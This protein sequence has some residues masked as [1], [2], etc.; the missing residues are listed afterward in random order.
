MLIK[1]IFAQQGDNLAGEDLVT[2]T[3]KSS[4]GNILH[5]NLQLFL[6]YF[7]IKIFDEELDSSSLLVL[8]DDDVYFTGQQHSCDGSLQAP[9]A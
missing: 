9:R 5:L 8:P 7:E 3:H 2:G 1:K 6:S 4:T